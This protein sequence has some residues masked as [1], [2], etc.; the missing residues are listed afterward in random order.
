MLVHI[1]NICSDEELMQDED[2]DFEGAL[3]QFLFFTARFLLVEIFISLAP[4]TSNNR[5]TYI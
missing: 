4:Y 5:S 1:L 2:D 3:I